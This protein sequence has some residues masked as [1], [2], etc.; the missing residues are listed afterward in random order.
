MRL[1]EKAKKKLETDPAQFVGQEILAYDDPYNN[2]ELYYW[3]REGRGNAEVDYVTTVDS[4]IIPIEVKAGATGTLKSLRIL[5]E[6]KKLP[7][8]VRISQHKLGLDKSVLS[9]PLYMISE[10][11]RL[12]RTV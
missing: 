12:V 5:M 3:A 9:I 6:E 8:G 4:Q 2:N 10:L 11:N 1:S 7:L